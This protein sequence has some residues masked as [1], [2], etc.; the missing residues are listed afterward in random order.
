MGQ[1]D[2]PVGV[3]KWELKVRTGANKSGNRVRFCLNSLIYSSLAVFAAPTAAVMN[4]E[5]IY[6]H[7]LSPQVKHLMVLMVAFKVMQPL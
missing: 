4:L 3:G 7:L 6:Y 5:G 2:Q 1:Y